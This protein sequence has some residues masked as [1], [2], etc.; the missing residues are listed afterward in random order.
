M[1]KEELLESLN[2]MNK[3]IESLKIIDKKNVQIFDLKKSI[4]LYGTDIKSAL[5]HYNNIYCQLLTNFLTLEEITLLKAIL[6]YD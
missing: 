4:K 6:K 1:K 3:E 5:E 2:K